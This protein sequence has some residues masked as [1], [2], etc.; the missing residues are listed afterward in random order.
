MPLILRER[1]IPRYAELFGMTPEQFIAA[2]D[3]II[4]PPLP[5]E[6]TCQ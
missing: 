4:D 2:Y 3:V 1:E 6:S 5:Q